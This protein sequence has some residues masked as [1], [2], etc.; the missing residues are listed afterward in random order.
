MSIFF[1]DREIFNR[2][3]DTVFDQYFERYEITK[4]HPSHF[5]GDNMKGKYWDYDKIIEDKIT[6][7]FYLLY[8]FL[9]PE[10]WEKEFHKNEVI[11]LW[12]DQKVK[13]LW[14]VNEKIA[15]SEQLK[16]KI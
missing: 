11:K 7:D 5:W 2:V 8:R 9:E 4:E 13:K 12:H 14:D 6:F 1:E 16:I 15:K 10:K 3:L